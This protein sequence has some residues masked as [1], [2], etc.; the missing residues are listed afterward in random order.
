[1]TNHDSVWKDEVDYYG[2]LSDAK[3]IDSDVNEDRGREELLD[4]S[5]DDFLNTVE[6]GIRSKEALTN[7][8]EESAFE[9]AAEADEER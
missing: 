4:R 1:M 2:V 3:E 5:L 6:A 7:V 8:P 9:A